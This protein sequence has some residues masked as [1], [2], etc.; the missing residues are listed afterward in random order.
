LGKLE[1]EN[2]RVDTREV[3]SSR[4]LVLLG[5]KGK[6]VDV[7][8]S[9]GNI[10]VVLIRLNK[11][12]VRTKA[13]LEAVVAIELKLGANNGVASSVTGSKT[14]VVGTTG[15]ITSSKVGGDVALGK[16]TRS[17]SVRKVDTSIKKGLNLGSCGIKTTIAKYGRNIGEGSGH[18][19]S[20]NIGV[21]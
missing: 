9:S 12:E 17:K 13:L 5:L 2:S 20:F 3:A 19:S 14:G 15:G 21:D 8:T 4:R 1:L 11:V 18:V 7:D 6:G 10:G 16:G